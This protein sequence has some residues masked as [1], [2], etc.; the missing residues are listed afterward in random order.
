[1]GYENK[2][3]NPIYISR[4]IQDEDEMDILLI[5]EGEKKHYVN[6]KDF[7]RM[8]YNKTKDQHRKHF[9]K[10]CLQCF[11]TEETLTKHKVN[12]IV[13]NGK[14]AIRMPKGGRKVQFQNHHRQ[15]PVPFVIYA[16]FEAITEKLSGC[17][18]NGSKSHTDKYQ[19]HTG[20]SYGYKV[21]FCY[22]DTSSKPVQI[23]RRED[24][25][26]KFMQEIAKNLAFKYTSQEFQNEKLELMRQNRVYPCDF[27]DSFAKFDTQE[28]P[29]KGAF[30]SIL[31]D[32]GISDEQYQH[33][34]KVWDTFKMKTMGEY[35]EL[36]LKSDILSLADVFENFR[37]TC[38]Q[39][40]RLDPAHYY[41][42]PGLSWD[43]MLEMTGIKLELMTDVDMFQFIAKGIR[44]GVRYIAH[45]HGEANNSICLITTL[46]NQVSTSCIW[47]P[48]ICMG[49]P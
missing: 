47:T 9:C 35:H 46:R 26:K 2:E 18:P 34:L 25:I 44:G 48:I 11:S 36:Y 45:R 38:L 22:D 24:S 14:Q 21:V 15:M 41:T 20:C 30:Y 8:M 1:M 31:T 23:Y 39:Y 17:Q 33:A 6:I 42:S 3:F 12:C 32:D 49:G 13:I 10:S 27:M 43:A 40:R 19:K 16:D 5:A 37:K 4:G 29:P 28:L 7:N